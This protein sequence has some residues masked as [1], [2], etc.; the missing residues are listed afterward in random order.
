MLPLDEQSKKKLKDYFQEN[1]LSY[2]QKKNLETM[3]RSAHSNPVHSAGFLFELNLKE[4]TKL[5]VFYFIFYIKK[6]KSVFFPSIVFASCFVSVCFLGAHFF[7][8]KQDQDVLSEVAAASHEKKQNGVEFDLNGDLDNLQDWIDD[9]LSED[10]SF[11]PDLPKQL[12]ENYEA[13][14]GHFFL[15]QGH[16]GVSIKI[17]PSALAMPYGGKWDD[18]ILYIVQLDKNMESSFPKERVLRKIRSSTGKIRSI[19]A[20]RE[21]AYGYAMVQ[22]ALFSEQM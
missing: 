22:P 6:I 2:Q 9:L 4:K 18:S 8:A 12:V 3:L 19:F 10:N 1:K 7:V 16:Q 13:H 15:Y 5:I 21:G 17:K 11:S 14:K 20:W